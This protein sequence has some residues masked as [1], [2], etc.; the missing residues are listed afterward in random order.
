MAMFRHSCSLVEQALIRQKIAHVE[1]E[2]RA[3]R[4]LL[5]R[6]QCYV[7]AGR[8]IRLEPAVHK[9]PP[10]GPAMGFKLRDSGPLK[11]GYWADIV[12]LIHGREANAV[13]I[14]RQRP[15]PVWQK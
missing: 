6:Q 12:S 1:V 8:L 10:R 9:M 13:L 7:H 2:H 3:Q 5:G 4:Q 11:V 14:N 15:Y